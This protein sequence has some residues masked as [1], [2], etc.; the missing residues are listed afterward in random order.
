MGRGRAGLGGEQSAANS[1][2]TAGPRHLSS[3]RGMGAG[4]CGAHDRCGIY[5]S[6]R[7]HS[8]DF[9][10]ICSTLNNLFSGTQFFLFSFLI[11]RTY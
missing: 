1:Y 11:P 10:R 4:H 3:E 2:W 9:L 5:S 7:R 6:D 8:G